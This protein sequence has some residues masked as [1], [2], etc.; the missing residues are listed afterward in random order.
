VEQ[1]G[2]M[3][4][5]N[6][7][8]KPWGGR[9]TESTD[10]FVE[11]FTASIGFDQRL[12]RHDIAGSIAHARMLAHVGIITAEESER[13]TGG[14]QDILADIERGDFAWSVSLEDIHMN[15][16]ARLI[17]RIGETGKKLHTGRSRNDQV[18]TDLRLYLRE[19]IDA[20]CA[21][22]D[23]HHH[24][25]LHPPA[26]RHAGHLRPPPAGLDRDAGA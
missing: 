8:E 19:E 5:D 6:S 16:E 3:T 13:I 26:G 4:D 1:A 14:L 18:A 10:A 7:S 21:E 11:A 17:D 22:I 15:I 12:Y 9:F 23:R 25:R 20:V 24:A 2:R